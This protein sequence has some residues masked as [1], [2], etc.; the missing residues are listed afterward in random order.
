M[1]SL[2]KLSSHRHLLAECLADL[3]TQAEA[4][5][6]LEGCLGVVVQLQEAREHRGDYL[7]VNQ[8]QQEQEHQEAF[9][10]NRAVQEAQV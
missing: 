1:G 5:R 10:D 4:H 9:S 6:R 7:V 2:V 3:R 8:L